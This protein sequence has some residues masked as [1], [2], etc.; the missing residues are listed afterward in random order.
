MGRVTS[1]LSTYVLN[2][3]DII[4]LE[5]ISCSVGSQTSNLILTLYVNSNQINQ[6]L[7]T[8]Q[9]NSNV[10]VVLK[11]DGS[12]AK[13]TNTNLIAAAEA[14]SGQTFAKNADGT[15]TLNEANIAIVEAVTIL[16]VADLNDPTICDEIE[17]FV[18]LKEL[19]C[20]SNQLTSLDVSNNTALTHLDCGSNRLTSLDVSLNTALKE[21]YCDSN[22]LTSLDVSNNTAL[23]SLWCKSNRLT[24]LDMSHN[25]ALKEFICE[26]NQ[27][28]SLDVSNNTAL[29]YLECFGNQLTTLDISKNLELNLDRV[30][31]GNQSV[32]ELTLYVN[33]T[34]ISQTL[35]R[36]YNDNVTVVLKE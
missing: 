9:S 7:D 23:T 36:S 20:G 27:L 2:L 10:K 15:V 12:A 4:E 32:G 30:L 34:Q 33:G 31:A 8:S 14:S 13:L 3:S 19:Y 25:T 21:L 5:L 28:T 24:S 6:S 11:D 35:N 22:Q 29:T 17:H 18:N 1:G 16:N 26:Y